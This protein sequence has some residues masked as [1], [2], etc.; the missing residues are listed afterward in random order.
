MPIKESLKK[1]LV[2][3]GFVWVFLV[4]LENVSQTSIE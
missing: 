4:Y 3:I 1:V 2:M